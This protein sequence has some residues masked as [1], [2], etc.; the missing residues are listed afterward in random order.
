MK[1]KELIKIGFWWDDNEEDSLYPKVEQFIG[2]SLGVLKK[3]K[4]VA[5]LK[6]GRFVNQY[7]GFSECRICGKR[8]GNS[9]FTDGRFLYPE[10]LLHYIIEHNIRIPE[11]EKYINS[12]KGEK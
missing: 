5:Y 8:N 7:L 2:N 10:G 11:L 6:K 12:K 4:I 1:N 3:K 9:E